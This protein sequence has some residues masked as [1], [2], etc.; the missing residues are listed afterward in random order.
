M[1]YRFY[2]EDGR[3]FIDLKRFPFNKE[4][5]E[6]VIGADDI[7]DR[8]SAG[9]SEVQLQVST[10]PI[11]YHDGVLVK[12]KPN[13]GSPLGGRIY[14]IKDGYTSTYKYEGIPFVWLCPVVLWLFWFYPKK[15]YFKVIKE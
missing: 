3:W 5:L 14:N 12:S 10:G 11:P 15:L 13:Y 9:A 2:N 8:V 7:L 6:M 1:K 4:W